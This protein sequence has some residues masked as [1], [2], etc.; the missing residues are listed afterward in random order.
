MIVFTEEKKFTG[1]KF[2]AVPVR[3]MDFRPVSGPAARG[4]DDSSVFT[5]WDGDRLVGLV[6]LLDD[7]ELVAH[8]L[9]PG[10]S[11]YHGRLQEK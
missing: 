10:A 3:W 2:G 11:D 1:K 5:A 6:R 8:A 4:P 9:C 7:N